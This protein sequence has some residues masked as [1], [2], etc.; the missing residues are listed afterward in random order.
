MCK[1]K[2]VFT[3]VGIASWGS[4]CSQ[5]NSPGVFTSTQS[6]VKWMV[7]K[8][9][10]E[11]MKSATKVKEFI[12]KI[13][14]PVEN[15]IND[16]D[17]SAIE[18]KNVEPTNRPTLKN[19]RKRFRIQEPPKAQSIPPEFKEA[20]QTLEV[21]RQSQQAQSEQ[22]NTALLQIVNTLLKLKALILGL[23]Q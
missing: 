12:P 8:V 3:V 13:V 23:F 14:V 20:K 4:G 17:P 9:I 10:S 16:V 5:I 22:T 21:P 15:A 18:E 2:K 19:Y 11:E 1:R 6:F 7:D